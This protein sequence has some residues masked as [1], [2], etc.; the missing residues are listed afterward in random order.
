MGFRDTYVKT[1]WENTRDST[2]D[3]NEM[4]RSFAEVNTMEKLY[5]SSDVNPETY[6]VSH[7]VIAV[8]GMKTEIVC[9]TVNALY[10]YC[11]AG[12]VKS[13]L[14]GNQIWAKMPQ[15]YTWESFKSTQQPWHDVKRDG[16][17]QCRRFDDDVFNRHAKSY[18][19]RSADTWKQTIRH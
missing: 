12:I 16:Y 6:K 13:E 18:L 4:W 7:C 14:P 3:S 11:P 5:V 9:L 1:V 10:I 8:T 19:P 2:R 17:G 15:L